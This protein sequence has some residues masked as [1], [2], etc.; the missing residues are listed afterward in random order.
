MRKS[1]MTINL[2]WQYD[3]SNPRA[4]WKLDGYS[5]GKNSG[6]RK[7]ID[8]RLDRT[9]VFKWKDGGRFDNGSDIEELN[10]SVK[11]NGCTLTTVKLGDTKE[12]IIQR[13]MLLCPSTMFVWV[14][15]DGITYYEMNRAEFVE[16]VL[17]FANTPYKQTLKI[18]ETAKML[19]WLEDRA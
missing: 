7:E 17:N 15:L 14:A 18:K 10:A 1:T 19:R 16:F 2:N 11:S 9:G 8:Y 6:E 12:E 13:F 3:E 5:K 4:P